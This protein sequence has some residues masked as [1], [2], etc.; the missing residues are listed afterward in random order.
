MAYFVENRT[1][2]SYDIYFSAIESISFY[3]GLNQIA[4]ATHTRLQSNSAYLR[5]L[6]IGILHETKSTP[7]TQIDD[8]SGLLVADNDGEKVPLTN[9]GIN[10]NESAAPKN[11]SITIEQCQAQK[12]PIDISSSIAFKA[13][14]SGWRDAAHVIEALQIQDPNLTAKVKQLF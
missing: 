10:N 11:K 12:L 9:T 8:K 2:C 1:L 6:E 4:D 13:P 5:Y 7:E 3:P 14:A